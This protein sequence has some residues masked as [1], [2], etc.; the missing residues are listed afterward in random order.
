MAFLQKNQLYKPIQH[1]LT[2]VDSYIEKVVTSENGF[3]SKS[4]PYLLRAGGKRLRPA[5]LLL[6]A[7]ITGY[8][9]EQSIKL[10]SAVELIHMASLIHDDIIDNDILRRGLPTL[11]T[12]IG[13]NLTVIVGDYIY[14][15]V[16][17]ILAEMNEIEIIQDIAGTTRL[18]ARGDIQQIQQKYNVHLTEEQYLQ[19]N[20]DKSASLMSCA[21]KLGARCGTTENGAVASLSRFGYNLGMA[22]QIADDLLDITAEEKVLG[23]PLGSDIREGKMTLPL[24]CI[25]READKNDKAWVTDLITSHTVDDTALGRIREMA[26]RYN[27]IEYSRNKAQ[28]YVEACIDACKDFEESELLSALID[29]AEFVVTRTS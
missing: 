4:V 17:T 1:E 9:G 5:L 23:K 2:E 13:D 29:F 19:I 24:I 18:M 21:C 27:G 16:F 8:T 26:E 3:F 10:A 22:F 6:S 28:H 20:A 11:N 25:L 7:K 14:S 15:L 12:Q